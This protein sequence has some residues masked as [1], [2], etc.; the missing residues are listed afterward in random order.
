MSTGFAWNGR[1]F[2]DGPAA[3]SAFVRD[4]P[5]VG[6]GGLVT[7]SGIPTVDPV[8]LVSFTTASQVIG[9]GSWV[10]RSETLQLP[11]CEFDSFAAYGQSDVLVICAFV[12]AFFFGFRTGMVP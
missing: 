1:C 3:L 7:L 8:G 2:S 4:V 10:T 5:S 9:S 11:P 6:S 12:F